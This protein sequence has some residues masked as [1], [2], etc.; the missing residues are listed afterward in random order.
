M[1][2]NNRLYHLC[3]WICLLCLTACQ[4]ETSSNGPQ[5][6]SAESTSVLES[7]QSDYPS[8]DGKWGFV[9]KGGRVV[10]K[11]TFDDARNF[12]EGMAVVRK[13]DKWGYIDKKGKISIACQ[14]KAAWSFAE[15]LARVQTFDDKMGFID[16]QGQ[17]V[18]PAEYE[19]LQ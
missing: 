2:T 4:Q 1:K 5:T 19:D 17:W 7:P 13:G 12:S 10:V 8:T 9:N 6:D 11:P 3:L 16:Q 15:K 18:V 14:F